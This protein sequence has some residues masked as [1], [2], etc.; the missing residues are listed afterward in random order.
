[1]EQVAKKGA[2]VLYHDP[3]VSEVTDDHGK[4]YVS[5]ELTDELISNADCVVFTTGHSCFDVDR[6]ISNARLVVDTRNAVKQVAIEDEK[7]FKL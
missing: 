4:Q 3:Y 1:M 7:V 6:I 2:N 5:V